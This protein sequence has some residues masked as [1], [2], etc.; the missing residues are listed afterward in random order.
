MGEERDAR[1]VEFAQMEISSETSSLFKFSPNQLPVLV[2]MCREH[3]GT[4]DMWCKTVMGADLEGL[5]GGVS[6]MV[7]RAIFVVAGQQ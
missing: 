1:G 7:N 5:R 2:F 6:E 4:G 3:G